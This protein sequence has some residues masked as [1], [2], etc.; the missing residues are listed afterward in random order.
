MPKTSTKPVAAVAE[1]KAPRKTAALKK[2]ADTTSTSVAVRKSSAVVDA[3]ALRE[4][5]R[6]QAAAMNERTVAPGGNK[7][8]IGQDKTFRLPDGS[9]VQELDAVIVEFAAIHN[10]YESGFDAKNIMPPGCFAVGLNPKVMAPVKES[11]NPQAGNCQECPMNVFGSD[12]DGK[13]CKNGRRLALLPP[14]ADGTDVEHDED[15]MT[16]DVSPTAIRGFDGYVQSVSRTFQT[17][18]FAVLTKIAFDDSVT[19][20]RLVFSD[21]RP[22][23]SI[24][25]VMAR[26]DEARDL[27]MAKP[28]F[29]GWVDPKQR[30]K[31]GNGARPAAPVAKGRR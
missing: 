5:L 6:Q 25:E 7:I 19:Y 10:F 13:A 11:P 31:G 29:S 18:P 20:A 21:P 27:I 24:G 26:Q 2:D 30:G 28:D 17:P 3:N 15:L 12:G 1:T 23:N 16:L 8:Q 22:I 14:N 9:K 4:Q